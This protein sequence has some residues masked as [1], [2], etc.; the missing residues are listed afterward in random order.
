MADDLLL[1]LPLGARLVVFAD[2][3]L[4]AMATGPSAR[5]SQEV[6]GVIGSWSGPGAVV[7]AGD[8]FEAGLDRPY[9]NGQALVMA[10]LDAHPAFKRA[11]GEFAAG[12]G[13]SVVIIPGGRDAWLGYDPAAGRALGELTGARVA[14]AVVVEMVTVAGLRRAR[15]EAGD[16]R[17]VAGNG[18]APPP[19]LTPPPPLSPAPTPVPPAA[20]GRQRLADLLPGVWRGSTSGWLSGMAELDDTSAVSRFVASRLVY[21]QFVRRAWLLAIPLGAALLLRLPVALLRPAHHMA[22]ILLASALGATALELVVLVGLLL[23]SLRQVWLAFSGPGG[24]PRDLNEAARAAARQLAMTGWA[25]LVTGGPGRPE[26]SRSSGGGFYANAGS[27]ADIV[28]E[29]PVKLAAL[30]LPA[31]FLEV[32]QMSWVELEAGNELHARLL[33]GQVLLPGVTVAERLLARL[34]SPSPATGDHVRGGPLRPV[35]KARRAVPAP[36]PVV[37]ATYPKGPVWPQ[38]ASHQVPHRR[39]RRL[40]AL[41]VAAAGF[42][43]VVSTLSRPIA[44][45]LDVVRQFVPLAV[46]QAAGALAALSGV[47]LIMLARGIRRGQRRAYVVC[48]LALLTVAVAHLLRGGD[49]A[50]PVIALAAAAYLWVRR[51]SFSASSD[52]PPVRRGLARIAVVA[53]A[54][55][56]AAT[57]TLEGTSWVTTAEDHR[58]RARIGWGQALLATVER[59]VGVRHVPLPSRLDRFFTPAMVSVALALVVSVAW[60]FF[61][62][63]VAHRQRSGGSGA[64]EEARAVVREFGAGTLD[65]FALRSD[66]KFYFWGNT[67]VA[68]AVYSGVCLV[69]PDPIGPPEQREGAW[70]AFRDFADSHGWS[71]AVMGASEDWLPIYRTTGMHDLYVGDEAVVRTG[72][73]SLEGG[74]FKGLRQ[75]VKRV[76]RYGYT[77][78]FHDPARVSPELAAELQDVLTKSRRGGV[79]RG[80]SMTL[81]RIF[82]PA[83]QGLL[84]AVVHG[85]PSTADPSRSGAAV[86]FCQ[87]VPAPAIEGYSLDLM[88]RD[89]AEHPNGLIDFAVVETVRYLAERGYKGLGLNFAT[90][91]AVLAGEAGDG[92][93]QKVQA[94]LLRRMSGP[95]Q[96]ES[97]WRFNA[98]FDPDWQPR[99]AVY[100]AP[101]HA[102][103]AALA[104]ARAESF[105]ELPIIGRFL[106]PSAQRQVEAA[107]APPPAPVA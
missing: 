5:A 105:W 81:G 15:I 13:R 106:V 88:R 90:M 4:G 7:I 86:A 57:L 62:P 30:G 27:C 70:R 20:P 21:R 11:L 39:T 63:V 2:L 75:A 101:E 103:P 94:W 8:L 96:I 52:L 85:P 35:A 76:A 34:P 1:E 54:A 9:L 43:S 73:F 102:L 80:F 18:A 42:F 56:G 79:E 55:V 17:P 44:A 45:R 104:V 12:P 69:S 68:Y 61:R 92:L 74:K 67:L 31:P 82:D 97:L 47:C 40:A 100:D 64:L 50:S 59:M 28:T 107:G 84:L 95:M 78:S 23:V 10:A 46:P 65:Y 58:G 71:L 66:K 48:Q 89:N 93:P 33:V 37:V 3:R 49:I 26:L 14:V 29:C 25:G 36:V 99:Y 72:K 19:L 38:V 6:A 98:K 16:H 22:G 41:V 83:D 24:G 60:F 77:I 91:R 51:A 53:V 32:R 87:Y